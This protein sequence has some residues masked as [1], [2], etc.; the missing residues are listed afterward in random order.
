MVGIYQVLRQLQ[1]FKFYVPNLARI[2]DRFAPGL[3][4][5][6]LLG[7]GSMNRRGAGLDQEESFENIG[8]PVRAVFRVIRF[9]SG[10][11]QVCWFYRHGE[12]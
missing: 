8:Y 4:Y 12:A 2:F 11:P 3:V 5:Q 1:I 9:D 10:L 6:P 7:Q